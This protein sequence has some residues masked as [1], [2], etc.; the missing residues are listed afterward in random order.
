MAVVDTSQQHYQHFPLYD[1][2]FDGEK[3]S[4]DAL[5]SFES[6][7]KER[8]YKVADDTPFRDFPPANCR[9]QFIS[10]KALP[11]SISTSACSAA[12]ASTGPIVV[13]HKKW[14][15]VLQTFQ[16]E[17]QAYS[18]AGKSNK[19]W[20]LIMGNNQVLCSPAF[21]KPSNARKLTIDEIISISKSC[22]P[23][24][25]DADL[26]IMIGALQNISFPLQI[27]ETSKDKAS[28]TKVTAAIQEMNAQKKLLAIPPAS[29]TTAPTG[30]RAR[31]VAVTAT[32]PST[33]PS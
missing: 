24:A 23:K 5:Y 31:V 20:I 7:E 13:D 33:P 14:I 2:F 10:A 29:S 11:T 26:E 27:S 6:E 8:Y 1:K 9:V 22:L 30:L 32:T 21:G 19:H 25:T 12:A 18:G 3:T 15:K 17:G 4:E 16:I 28:L